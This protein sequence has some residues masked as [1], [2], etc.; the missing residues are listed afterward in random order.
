MDSVPKCTTVVSAIQRIN[1]REVNM[2][3]FFGVLAVLA[4]LVIVGLID[5][6]G[7]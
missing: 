2:Q 3:Y 1:R 7:G 4:G 6:M 5:K